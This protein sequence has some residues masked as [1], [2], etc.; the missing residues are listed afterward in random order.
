MDLVPD[1]HVDCFSNK[2][3]SINYKMYKKYKENSD[4]K[5]SNLTLIISEKAL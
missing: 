4:K 2:L 3:L 1:N 5:E